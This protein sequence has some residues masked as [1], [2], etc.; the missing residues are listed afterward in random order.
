MPI[1][2]PGRSVVG[3]RTK[4]RQAGRLLQAL[5]LVPLHACRL[6]DGLCLA[7]RAEVVYTPSLSILHRCA[8]R[9]RFRTARPS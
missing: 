5:H 4:D 7:D 8:A 1:T 3:R 6:E 2:T 9:R